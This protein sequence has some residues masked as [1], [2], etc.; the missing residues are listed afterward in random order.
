MKKLLVLSLG[1]LLLIIGRVVGSPFEFR[2]PFTYVIATFFGGLFVI[3]LFAFLVMK[4]LQIPHR[5]VKRG[6]L[7]LIGIVALPYFISFIWTIIITGG[8]YLPMWQDVSIY[9]NNKGEKVIS[10]WRETSGS[11]Y[12]YRTRKIIAD[13][14]QFRISYDCDKTKLDGVWTEYNLET[15]SKS[16]VNFNDNRS[17]VILEPRLLGKGWSRKMRMISDCICPIK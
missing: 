1:I 5:K 15:R 13:F 17:S 12:D 3:A 7:S 9:T 4:S 6:F 14:G 16:T 10:E 11:I 2:E 8:N